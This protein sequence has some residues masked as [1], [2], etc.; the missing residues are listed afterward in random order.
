MYP[1]LIPYGA[2]KSEFIARNLPGKEC[3]RQFTDR[4]SRGSHSI[5][6]YY[7]YPLLLC[8]VCR[9]VCI[10]IHGRKGNVNL[11]IPVWHVECH[12][13]QTRDP[14]LQS[15]ILVYLRWRSDQLWVPMHSILKFNI[16]NSKSSIKCWLWWYLS[17]V[18]N[19]LHDVNA[20]TLGF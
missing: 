3:G 2:I 17:T 15:F 19:S 11:S 7:Y 12:P 18:S 6:I 5:N 8:V 16:L 1:N 9:S 20:F 4:T 14:Y 10:P 13:S